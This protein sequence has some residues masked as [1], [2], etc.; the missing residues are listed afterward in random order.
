M[1]LGAHISI[2]KGY[3]KAIKQAV[4]I[5]AN[6]LQFF[7]RNP[8]GSAAKAL[9]MVDIRSASEFSVAKNFG[10][11]VS[12]APY[13]INLGSSKKQTRDFAI[14]VLKEDQK[15]LNKIGATYLVLH[16]GSHLGDGINEGIYRI[17][18]GLKEAVTDVGNVMILLE[19]MAGSGSEVGYTF[20]Q[21]YEIIDKTG[22]PEK[23]GICLDTCHMFAAGY[24]IV[25]QLDRVIEEFNSILGLDKLKVIH[26]N[27]SKYQLGSRK[28]RHANIGE[29]I[30]GIGCFKN[31]ITHPALKEKPF[32]LETPGGLEY[33][34]RE[35]QLLKEL[36]SN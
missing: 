29:G 4:E 19:G 20:E 3:Y 24:D 30:L 16:P 9:D 6:T 8:R 15:R 32:L 26:L 28:D 13:T 18:S 23:F 27:D 10:P 31:V 17:S 14:M 11:L 12:H 22:M 7:S 36:Y 34:K 21:L 25:S 1:L 35:I 2:S 33:Y 5:G